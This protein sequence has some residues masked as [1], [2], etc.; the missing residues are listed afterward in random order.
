MKKPWVIHA[1]GKQAEILIYE[2]IGEGWFGGVSAKAFADDLKAL[3]SVDAL[4]IRINSYGGAI[5]DGFA[6][7]NTLLRHNAH[8]VVHVD[9]VAASSASVIA[10]AG[11]EIRVAA[12]GFVMIHNP[13]GFCQGYADELRKQAELLDQVRGAIAGV[14]AARTNLDVGEILPLMDAETWMDANEAVTKGF[15]DAIALENKLAARAEPGRFRRAPEA[16]LSPEATSISNPEANRQ[17]VA[18]LRLDA[19]SMNQKRS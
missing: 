10:M 15:A 9:G 1:K 19:Q 4:D 7:Y 18:R 17:R 6:I 8:K 11:D 13:W 14:Y 3:G 2:D 16:L 12:N 5:F